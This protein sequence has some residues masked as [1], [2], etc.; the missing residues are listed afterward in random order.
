[1]TPLPTLRAPRPSGGSH[2]M[3][4]S[5]NAPVQILLVEDS[6]DDANLMI[7]A[8]QEGDLQVHIKHLEDGE[9]AIT[10][11]RRQGRAGDDRRPDLILLDL[12][13]PRKS[14]LEILAELKED[15]DLRRI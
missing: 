6:V 2:A 13:L 1:M 14:G 5:S 10:F 4:N 9:D 3:P 7:N 11:L 12:F 15:P 8:L